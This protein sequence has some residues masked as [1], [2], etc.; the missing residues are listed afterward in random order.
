VAAKACATGCRSRAT[1]VPLPDLAVKGQDLPAVVQGLQ[2][3]IDG[4][5]DLLVVANGVPWWLLP[6]VDGFAGDPVVRSVDPDGDVLRRLPPERVM[7]GV[8]HFS[9]A[10][11]VPGRVVHVSGSEI[12]IGEP[13]GG[14]SERVRRWA[15]ALSAGPVRATSVEDIRQAAWEKL[16]GNVNI[17]PV[18]ALTSATVEEILGCPEVRQLCAAMFDEAAAVGAVFDGVELTIEAGE[19]IALLGENGAGKSTLLSLI[20]G[21]YAPTRGQVLLDGHAVPD[22]P[23]RWL[24]QQ[25]AMVLQETFLFSGTLADNIRYGRPDATDAEIAAVAQAALV[26][27]FADLLPDGLNTVVGTG[28]IGLSGGQRQRVGI[29]RALLVNAPVVLL[30]EPTTGLDSHAEELVVEALARLVQDRTVIMTTHRPAV[31]ALATRTVHLRRGGVLVT[32]PAMPTSARETVATGTPALHGPRREGG[33]ARLA[34]VG[35]L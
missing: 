3:W 26:S 18:S 24:H 35:A 22:T 13:V 16:L 17:N 10:I 21:L 29:A 1:P 4:G 14:V 6:T 7:A 20:G 31:T 33:R 9:S 34:T 23:E 30:D 5:V 8:A 19:R 27:E 32:E 15:A 25:V 2:Q 28:G 11:D 12:L